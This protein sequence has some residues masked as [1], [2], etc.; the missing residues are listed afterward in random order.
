MGG[1]RS[2]RGRALDPAKQDR[3]RTPLDPAQ[4]RTLAAFAKLRQRAEAFGGG[5]TEHPVFPACESGRIDLSRPQVGFRTAWRSLVKAAEAAK[6]SGADP[7][8]AR[9]RAAKPFSGF[10][11]HD[12]RHQSITELAEAGISDAAMQSIAGH[13]SRKMLDHY[14]HVRMAAK[15]EAVQALGG[16]LIESPISAEQAHG[17]ANGG[18]VGPA[19]A[20]GEPVRESFH[21]KSR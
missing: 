9:K 21:E 3:G 16:D 15:R 19:A 14:S 1:C 20:T 17:K 7:E 13:K 5:G 12:L 10:R 4:S 11:F 6:A 18:T 8:D 2:L